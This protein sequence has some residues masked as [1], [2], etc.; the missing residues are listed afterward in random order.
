VARVDGHAAGVKAAALPIAE[1]CGRPAAEFAKALPARIG[2]ET[3]AIAGGIPPSAYGGS[4]RKPSTAISSRQHQPAEQER[5]RSDT[6][7]QAQLSDVQLMNLTL[8]LTIRD[9]V[10]EDTPTGCCRFG[11]DALQAER[12][13]TLGIHQILAIV[14][15]VGDSSLFRVRADLLAL[16]ESPLPLMRTLAAVSA[17]LDPPH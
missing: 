5:N 8:L 16:L 3:H 9:S 13:A 10:V 2:L 11:L 14:A 6:M 1:K 7:N 12:I 4:L 17:A 15:N